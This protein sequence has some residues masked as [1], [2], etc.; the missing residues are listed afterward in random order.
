LKIGRHTPLVLW[1]TSP[2]LGEELRIGAIVAIVTI[3]AIGRIVALVTLVVLVGMAVA[4]TPPK[5]TGGDGVK[6]MGRGA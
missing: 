6:G 2:N 5:C 4:R 1:T 3:G